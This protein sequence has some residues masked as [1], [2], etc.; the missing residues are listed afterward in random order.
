MIQATV[1]RVV[2]AANCFRILSDG[3]PGRFDCEKLGYKGGLFVGLSTTSDGCKKSEKN[4][5]K[6]DN[7][8]SI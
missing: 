8:A 4:G 7:L 3:N 2:Q 5:R 6:P 1:R